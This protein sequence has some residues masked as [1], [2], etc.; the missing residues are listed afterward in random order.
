MMI[1]TVKVKPDDLM[2]DRDCRAVAV[3]GDKSATE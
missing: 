3:S 1:I 2:S